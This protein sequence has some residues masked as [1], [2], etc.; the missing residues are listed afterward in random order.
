MVDLTNPSAWHWYK[1]IIINNML[2]SGGYHAAPVD[3]WMADFGESVPLNAWLFNSSV[4][5]QYFHTIYPQLWA[6]LNAEA[7]KEVN[8]TGDVV[9][10]TRSESS[11][12]P[13]FSTLFWLGDQLVTWDG[14]DGLQTAITGMLSSAVSGFSLTHSD[15][16]SLFDDVLT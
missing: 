4:D 6:Q 16:K 15:G 12:S 3:G 13:Q 10:F 2:S 8:R 7:I 5:P 9:F 1:D 14:C 11:Q